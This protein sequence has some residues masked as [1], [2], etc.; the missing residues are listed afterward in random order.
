M[1]GVLPGIQRVVFFD[2]INA[3]I[4]VKIM[5]VIKLFHKCRR[6]GVAYDLHVRVPFRKISDSGG[7][8]GFHVLHNKII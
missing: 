1:Q 7:M 2:C 8:I 6:F 3:R 5:K 4:Y